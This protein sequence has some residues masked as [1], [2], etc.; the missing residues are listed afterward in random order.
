[1]RESLP[2]EIKKILM[3]CNTIG[4]HEEAARRL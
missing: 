2:K 4:N 3:L 1:M